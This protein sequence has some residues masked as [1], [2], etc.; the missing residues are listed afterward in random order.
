[1]CP[2]AHASVCPDA[3]ASVCPDVLSSLCSSHSAVLISSPGAEGEALVWELRRQHSN[4]Q[5][6]A[7]HGVAVPQSGVQPARPVPLD[8]APP[9]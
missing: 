3:H 7:Q 5:D 8:R 1:M 4:S 9:P 6:A 2:D